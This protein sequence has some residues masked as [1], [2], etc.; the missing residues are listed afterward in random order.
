MSPPKTGSVSCCPFVPLHHGWTIVWQSLRAQTDPA[1]E[2][3]AVVDGPDQQIQSTLSG[4]GA[5]Q[6]VIEQSRGLPYA[7]NRGLE[8]CRGFP[9][10]QA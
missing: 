2:L 3:V 1:W 6:V 10:G 8:H 5:R 9:D 4:F 7:L